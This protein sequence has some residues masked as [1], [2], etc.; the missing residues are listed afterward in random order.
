MIDDIVLFVKLVKVGNYSLLAKLINS[1]QAT[2]SRRIQGLEE[3]LN[4]SLFYRNNRQAKLTA[5]GQLLYERF[6][7]VVENLENGWKN[8]LD[9]FNHELSGT[10][11]L[12]LT[13]EVARDIV[14]PVLAE[15]IKQ[16]PK[17]KL[18]VS[19]TTQ[20]IHLLK[21]TYDIAISS[22][23]PDANTHE[24]KLLRQIKFKLYATPAYIAK[25]GNPSTIEELI[26]KH[27]CIGSL[28]FEGEENNLYLAENIYSG[29]QRTVFYSSQLYMDTTS[30]AII[31][32]KSGEY[33]CGA[34]DAIV[35]NKIRHGVLLEVLPEYSFFEIPCYLVR[36]P[37]I[38][39][40]IERSLIEFIEKTF[41][42]NLAASMA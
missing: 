9:S 17:I 7:N 5:E 42:N 15:F 8:T 27:N 28:G 20:K 35:V 3:K 14:L 37:G 6:C 31:V 36:K 39:N 19:F 10:L 1:T 12:A 2:V 16:Y 26:N 21:Q 25:Y 41:Q 38:T 40:A 18:H 23:L 22:S 13:T 4:V 32:A 33:I 34:W 29:D 30:H 24:V 11:R